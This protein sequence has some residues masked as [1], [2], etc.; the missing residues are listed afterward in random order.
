ML[1]QLATQYLVY[2]QGVSSR[3]LTATDIAD[4]VLQRI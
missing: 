2:N 3:T 1:S 4:S